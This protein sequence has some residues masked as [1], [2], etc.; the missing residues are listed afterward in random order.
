MKIAF[1]FSGLIKDI[2]KTY[3][4]FKHIIE[5]YDV[6]VFLSTWDIED[7]E[8]G[9]T[10]QNFKDKY[11]PLICEIEN[12]KA[13]EDS[14]WPTISSNY[15]TPKYLSPKEYNKASRS[16]MFGLWYKIQKANYLTKLVEKDYDIV[17]KLRT[18]IELSDNFELK[19]NNYINFPHGIMNIP[20]WDN[21]YGPHD[22]IFYGPPKLMDYTTNLFYFISK[23]HSEGN[24]IYPPES[25]LRHHI[26][27][28]DLEIRFY[29]D[30]V[31]LRTGGNKGRFDLSQPEKIIS[32]KDWKHTETHPNVK[33]YKDE[34]NIT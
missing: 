23:Y 8:N 12:F 9:D 21:C 16:I 4:I 5:K 10:I 1:T 25:L 3:P 7:V 27:Q 31:K 22:F 30:V 18:D 34:I 11:N 17:V 28:R 32:S 19:L 14:F 24:Y 15:T 6:D 33:F 13:W 2:E 26:S 20:D 29:S